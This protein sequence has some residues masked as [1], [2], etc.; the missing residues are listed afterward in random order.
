MEFALDDA[1]KVKLH[2]K[3]RA[4]GKYGAAN[5]DEIKA[6]KNITVR[7]EREKVQQVGNQKSVAVEH[8]LSAVQ[9]EQEEKGVKRDR[10]ESKDENTAHKR[11]RKQRV[12][13]KKNTKDDDDSQQKKPSHGKK[14]QV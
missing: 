10:A 2:E 3:T 13:R 7:E 1:R 14:V 5:A 11:R 6:K 12:R 4:R 8:L 9:D